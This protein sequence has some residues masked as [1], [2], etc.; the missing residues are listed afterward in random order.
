MQVVKE[1]P[2]HANN[3]RWVNN[4]GAVK[5]GSANTQHFAYE[6]LEQELRLTPVAELHGGQMG[7]GP[8]SSGKNH[9]FSIGIGPNCP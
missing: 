5:C 7:R 8:P 1:F 2:N 3:N 9:P 4:R 6:V